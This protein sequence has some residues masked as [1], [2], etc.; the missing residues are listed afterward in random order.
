M[1]L[2]DSIY[3]SPWPQGMSL[4]QSQRDCEQEMRRLQDAERRKQ[5]ALYYTQ[6]QQMHALA[7]M[8]ASVDLGPDLSVE[9]LKEKIT[10]LSAAEALHLT[11]PMPDHVATLTGWRGWKVNKNGL[12]A[13]GQSSA[14]EPKKAPAAKCTKAS[15]QHDSPARDCT[16]GYWSFK[17]MDLLQEALKPYASSVVVVGSVD[18]WGKV[19]E[20]ENGFRSQYA[21]PKELWLLKPDLDFLSWTYGVPVRKTDV[22]K[23]D[24]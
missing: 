23:M 5:E 2:F 3:G 9:K 15:D 21:Y 13:L 17:S 14:W 22:Q 16:C 20:C 18:I 7:G 6:M 24:K 19:I 1:A 11:P 10:S 8:G 12:V 4:G